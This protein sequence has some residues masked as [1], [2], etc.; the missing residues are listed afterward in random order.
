MDRLEP[1]LPNP[2]TDILAPTAPIFLFT[3]IEDPSLRKFRTDIPLL[4]EV[5]FN[6]EI[7]DPRRAWLLSD[8]LE[9]KLRKSSTLN[10]LALEP[11][12]M[13]IPSLPLTDTPDPILRKERSETDEL[14]CAKFSKDRLEP[15]LAKLLNE[16]EDPRVLNP[17]ME[18]SPEIIPF[19]APAAPAPSS[20]Q[21]DPIANI[22]RRDN[23]LPSE[24]K[25]STET[26]DPALAKLLNESEEPSGRLFAMEILPLPA[27]KF[28][29]A[30]V[31]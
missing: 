29:Q 23:E 14:Q 21:V 28:P 22:D 31:P 25:F 12:E 4:H 26:E 17:R 2:K 11:L 5:K 1:T 20:E 7:A 19:E 16:T 13:S 30:A 3:D 24:A 15:I 18:I 9:P 27:T 10:L 6:M 8:K